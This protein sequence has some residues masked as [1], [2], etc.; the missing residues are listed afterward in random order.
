MNVTELVDKIRE[1]NPNADVA[2]VESA[3]DF[4]ARC[5]R[6][7]KRMS[8][9]PYLTHPMA[10]ADIIADM[11]L[12]VP[13][14]VTG[15]LHDTVEDT[16]ATLEE[17]GVAFGDEVA[18]LVDGVTKISLL[19][20]ESREEAEARSIRKMFVASARDIRVLL[21]KLA[22]RAHNMRTIEHLSP[23]KQGRIAEQTLGIYSPLAHRLGIYWLKSEFE[24]VAFQVLHADE[25]AELMDK[26]TLHK[27]QRDGYIQEITS[28][29]TKRMN[30][31][32]LEA[33]VTGRPKSAYSIYQKMNKQGLHYDDVYDVVAFRVLVDSDRDCYD[34]LGIVHNNWR[35]IPGRFRDYLALPKT[36]RYQSLHTTVIGPYGE[37][38]EVQIRTHEMHQVAEFG[39]AAH[40]KYKASDPRDAAEEERFEWLA[41]LLEWQRQLDDPQQFLHSVKEDLFAEE[42]VVFTPRGQTRTLTKGATIVDFAYRIHS[43]VGEHCAAA[44]V[45]GQLVPLRYQLQAGDTIEVITTSETRPSRDW[46]KFV[47][48]PRARERIVASIKLEE[49]GKARALGHELIERDLTRFQ[50]DLARLQREGRMADVLRHFER[51]DEDSLFEAIGYGRVRTKQVTEWLFPDRKD[52]EPRRQG[53]R[54]I[55]SLL[56]RQKK[57]S[58]GVRV[59]GADESM[60]RFG[61]CCSPLPGEPIVGF[62]TRGRGV[63]VHAADC[64]RLSTSDPERR[65]DVA[66]EK[67]TRAP[68]SVRLEVRSRDRPGLLARM[69]QAIA[70]AGVNIDRAYVRTTGE[71]K[72]QNVFE[73]TLFN[74]DELTRVSRNLRRV[75]GVKEVT[76]VR[77]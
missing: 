4:S 61:K 65:V 54:R 68:R 49:R 32:G 19:E 28:I 38:M 33:A 72:A 20:S 73:M 23:E 44:R 66:W 64:E 62:L 57:D 6:G 18:T 55:F 17:I 58:S 63:T 8:G 12:D 60:V 69:S 51:P 26:L 47:K 67:G 21:V 74:V 9:E 24:Q 56:E 39:I 76:R 53:L 71:G 25:Y 11:K 14:V 45:N 29:L 43:E 31:S 75:P 2:M 13:T 22:D 27:L 50:T 7:Q 41:Q 16:L 35:P 3:Y 15:L 42:V 46:L 34:A 48:T 36:N 10:V 37:R 70:S 59:S 77:T 40:W 30:E 1:Y 5:H 52:E